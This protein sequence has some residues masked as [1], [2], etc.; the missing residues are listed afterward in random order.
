VF[1]VSVSASGGYEIVI[2]AIAENR[3]DQIPTVTVDIGNRREVAA[4]AECNG[5]WSRQGLADPS[6]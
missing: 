6:H 4:C 3:T 2:G 5:Y 1:E